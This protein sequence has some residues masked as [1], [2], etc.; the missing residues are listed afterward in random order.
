MPSQAMRKRRA[1]LLDRMKVPPGPETAAMLQ[2]VHEGMRPPDDWNGTSHK[3]PSGTATVRAPT[4]FLEMAAYLAKAQ[5]MTRARFLSTLINEQL[6]DIWIGRYPVGYEQILLPRGS[7][8]RT[9]TSDR[10]GIRGMSA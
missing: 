1:Y 10:L 9:I 7:Q 5:G 4:A 8:G 6:A 2:K 3:P